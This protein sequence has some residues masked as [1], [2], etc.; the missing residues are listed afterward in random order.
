M[1]RA[2][3]PF[4]MTGTPGGTPGNSW[5]GYYTVPPGSPNPDPISDQKVSFSTPVFR[6]LK[7]IPI[8][9]PGLYAEIMSSFLKLERKQTKNSLNAFRIGIFLFRSYSFGIQ[10]ITTF[11]YAPVVPLK[12]VPNSRP[13]WAKC[14]PVFRPKTRGTQREDSFKPLKHSI[15]KR[16]LVVK[17]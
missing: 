11:N 1:N 14:I 16:I 15:V 7:S 17:R 4:C 5:W 6:P 12:T 3:P 2:N 13:K 10:T 9:R 8:F